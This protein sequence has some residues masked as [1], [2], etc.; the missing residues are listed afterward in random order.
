MKCYRCGKGD[1]EYFIDSFDPVTKTKVHPWLCMN[2]MTV[3]NIAIKDL[4][5]LEA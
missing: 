3:V 5:G 4:V 1:A 2:C